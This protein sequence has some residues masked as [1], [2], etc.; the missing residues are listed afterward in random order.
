MS[1]LTTRAAVML[2]AGREW[3]VL[4][5]EL[6]EP[7]VGEVL[8]RVE[9]AGLCHSD[10]H[11]RLDPSGSF[12]MVGGHEGAGV[13]E[14]VGPG[15]DG[16]AV[17][18][19][20]LCSFMPT[21]GRCRWCAGG[22]SYLCDLAAT[23]TTG[24]LP[25]G[26]F[27]FSLDGRGLGG[28]CLLGTFARR[29]VVSVASV[30]RIDE[31]IPLDIACLVSCGVLTGWGSVLYGGQVQVGDVVVVSGAGGVG[32]NAVHAAA[33]AGAAVVAAVDPV[34]AKREFALGYGATHAFATVQEAVEFLAAQPG[35]RL[36]DAAVVAVGDLDEKS[37]REA[38][39]VLGKGGRLVLAGLANRAD[40]L[41]VVLPGTELTAFN[42]T[43]TG[44]LFGAANPRVDAPRL[45]SL[46]RSGRLRLDT[47]ISG[48]YPLEDINAGY[49]DLTS[50]RNI[51]GLIA[52]TD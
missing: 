11:M 17:G 25:D 18:D 35:G 47:L 6:A 51:R 13:V 16:V 33:Q 2:G 30:I 41:N 43:V 8:V 34:P 9:Y 37:V 28:Y 23:L 50:G 1:G 29:A 22:R 32:V 42:K 36:A 31:D 44:A 45:L 49:D 39:D 20:V 26:T 21:C 24:E 19:H 27:R 14:A 46:Y 10:H 38:F 40:T 5:L 12:P 7:R 48:V 4:D 52:H 15:V 3:T